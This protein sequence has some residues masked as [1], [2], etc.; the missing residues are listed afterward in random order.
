LR[1]PALLIIVEGRMT[2]LQRGGMND[3]RPP[4][5]PG[6]LWEHTEYSARRGDL[7]G[8]VDEQ[9]RL[10]RSRSWYW[11]QV[12]AAI[13]CGVGRD[14]C[15]HWLLVLGAVAAG[16]VAGGL[17]SFLWGQLPFHSGLVRA[18]APWLG[19]RLSS[20]AWEAV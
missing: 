13:A 6:W 19:D 16:G 7:L 1:E 14:W 8:A 3:L 20:L 10:G 2:L 4:A 11:G 5:L 12:L 18:T 15:A 17:F 9:F